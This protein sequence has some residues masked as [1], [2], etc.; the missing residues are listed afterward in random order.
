LSFDIREM[1]I[2]GM[3]PVNIIFLTDYIEH[4]Y[5]RSFSLL[6]KVKKSHLVK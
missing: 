4:I 3:F 2:S 5:N 6:K 1:L